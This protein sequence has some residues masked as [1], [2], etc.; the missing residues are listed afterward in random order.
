M[1]QLHTWHGLYVI[2]VLHVGHHLSCTQLVAVLLLLLWVWLADILSLHSAASWVVSGCVTCHLWLRYAKRIVRRWSFAKTSCSWHHFR[3]W[4]VYLRVLNSLIIN[5]TPMLT[6][7]SLLMISR[8]CRIMVFGTSIYTIDVVQ[9]TRGALCAISSTTAL[10]V[11]WIHWLCRC[12]WHFVH[13]AFWF[14]LI[15][16]LVQR[17]SVRSA[18]GT[19]H[20]A[21]ASNSNSMLIGLPIQIGRLKVSILGLS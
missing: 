12:M 13:C 11:G 8:T 2:E 15:H 14:I 7:L 18:L 20:I 17:I 9:M 10:V 16:I 6:L 19:I 5:W 4:L 1:Q 3:N 21:K